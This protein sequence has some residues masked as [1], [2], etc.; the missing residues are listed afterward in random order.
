MNIANEMVEEDTTVE[1]LRKDY[2]NE[3]KKLEEAFLNYIGDNDLK[4]LKSEFPDKWKY[5]TKKLSYP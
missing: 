4:P 3:I 1:D 2:P 5:L